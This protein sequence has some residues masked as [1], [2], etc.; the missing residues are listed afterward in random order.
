PRAQQPRPVDFDAA[1]PKARP[2]AATL[3]TIADQIDMVVAREP[4]AHAAAAEPDEA[5]IEEAFEAET[6]APQLAANDT[7]EEEA[8]DRD[9]DAVDIDVITTML[10]RLAK[11]G[12]RL[13]QPSFE[14]DLAD[15]AQ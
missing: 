9:E 10:E 12:P 11:Q 5:D 6:S 8:A 3:A 4:A 2:Q 7:H 13:T 14:A 15:L 1:R